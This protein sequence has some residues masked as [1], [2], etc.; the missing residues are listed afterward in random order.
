[1]SPNK[2]DFLTLLVTM[3]IMPNKIISNIANIYHCFLQVQY[4]SWKLGSVASIP[5]MHYKAMLAT[6]VFSFELL[7]I[8]LITTN[9]TIIVINATTKRNMSIMK[10]LRKELNL[11]I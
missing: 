3:N 7:H 4:T 1:M 9:L 6:N 8:T 5:L 11:E 10:L 2:F